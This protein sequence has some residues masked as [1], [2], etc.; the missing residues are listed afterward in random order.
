MNQEVEA[1]G[2][3]YRSSRC[4]SV[5]NAEISMQNAQEAKLYDKTPHCDS[6]EHHDPTSGGSVVTP[7][8]ACVFCISCP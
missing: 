6:A 4:D 8:K 2:H 7:W 5:V 1:H 3:Q